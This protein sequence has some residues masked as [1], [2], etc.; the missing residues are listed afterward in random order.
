MTIMADGRYSSLDDA[1]AGACTGARLRP[2]PRSIVVRQYRLLAN[3]ILLLP[4]V[5]TSVWDARKI[6]NLTAGWAGARA[7]RVD[8][9]N[10]FWQNETKTSY[11]TQNLLQIFFNISPSHVGPSRPNSWRVVIHD[12]KSG[13]RRP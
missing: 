11:T 12:P 7:G 5:G 1:S 13:R 3:E 9:F 8:T 10:F 2:S 6:V 4:I